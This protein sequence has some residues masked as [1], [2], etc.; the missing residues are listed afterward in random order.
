MKI[1]PADLLLE[2]KSPFVKVRVIGDYNSLYE[3]CVKLKQNIDKLKFYKQ[4]NKQSHA[5]ERTKI[6]RGWGLFCGAEVDA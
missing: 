2:D 4:K 6:K 3:K 5:D 1:F